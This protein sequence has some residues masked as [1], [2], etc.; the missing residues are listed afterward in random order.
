MIPG[1]LELRLLGSHT[2][3]G[4]Y[5]DERALRSPRRRWRIP[6]AQRADGGSFARGRLE[7]VEETGKVW[8]GGNSC[9]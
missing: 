7:L 1:F 5:V 9:M 6:D 2:F 3:W 4:S 8:V